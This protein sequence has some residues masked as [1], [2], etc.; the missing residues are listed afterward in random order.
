MR[1]RTINTPNLVPAV[2]LQAFTIRRL[3][4]RDEIGDLRTRARI[5]LKVSGG[6]IYSYEIYKQE[7]VDCKAGF[8]Q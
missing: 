6:G 1:I 5:T 7:D 8:E 4:W 2:D 3:P